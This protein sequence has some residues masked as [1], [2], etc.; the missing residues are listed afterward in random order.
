MFQKTRKVKTVS[1]LYVGSK[2]SAPSH[3]FIIIFVNNCNSSYIPPTYVFVH[4]TLDASASLSRPS[5]SCLL[6][7]SP[8]EMGNDF[9]TLAFFSVKT[10]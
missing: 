4:V 9:V 1:I 6:A 7:G 8:L 3:E 10:I 2:V 5:L